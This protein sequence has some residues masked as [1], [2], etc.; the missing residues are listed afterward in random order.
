MSNWRI[1]WELTY[2]FR[3]KIVSH[4]SSSQVSVMLYKTQAGASMPQQPCRHHK[5]NVMLCN[6]KA[7]NYAPTLIRIG[8][9]GAAMRSRCTWFV[10]RVLTFVLLFFSVSSFSQHVAFLFHHPAFLVWQSR[11]R[12]R[13]KWLFIVFARIILKPKTAKEDSEIAKRVLMVFVISI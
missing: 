6:T 9:C 10:T 3:N 8:L 12:K 5:V 11:F 7:A 13:V 1:A 4:L 2:T